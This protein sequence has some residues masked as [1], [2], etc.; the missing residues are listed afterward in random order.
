MAGGAAI[1]H[2]GASAIVYAP[3]AGHPPD[4][5]A[6]PAPPAMPP[7]LAARSMRVDVGPPR[8]S[9][10]L[11]IIEPDPAPRETVFVLHGV[12]GQK[13][14]MLDWGQRLATA[15]Y[16]AVLVD[17]RGHG[18]SS[19]DF[20][21]YGVVESRDLSQA[22]DALTAQGL[23]PGRVG[24]MGVSYG[25]ATAV[26][27][28]GADPRVAAVVA[29]ASFASLRAVIPGYA[30]RFIPLVGSLVPDFLLARAV[31][32]AGRT[33]AFDPDA[34][35]PLLAVTRTRAPVLLLHGSEDT[36]ISPFHS[37]MIHARAPDH[38]EVVIVDGADH[39][40]IMAD[41]TGEVWRRSKAWFARALDPR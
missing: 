41:S 9:L 6:D 3:N 40:N 23:A 5:A 26:E 36:N 8:A 38:S 14:D 19:G 13:E 21:T 39:E 27:W 4:P 34:A 10:A 32:R 18:R 29:V 20:L 33:G 31:D 25:A 12:R 17:A 35:S 22:L 30:P 37:E 1:E 16:R 7:T 24:V 11:L 28:A 2:F 15:G